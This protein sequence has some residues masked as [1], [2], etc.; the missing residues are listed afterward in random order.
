MLENRPRPFRNRAAS[1]LSLAALS[2]LLMGAKDCCCS[3]IL[4]DLTEKYDYIKGWEC[5]STSGGSGCITLQS[6]GA[7]VEIS[8]GHKASFKE[9]CKYQG[10]V[11]TVALQ[12][13]FQ[14]P[15]GMQLFSDSLYFNFNGEAIRFAAD[16]AAELELES[17][18]GGDWVAYYQ[19]DPVTPSRVEDAMDQGDFGYRLV[20]TEPL[21]ADGKA[22]P[23]TLTYAKAIKEPDTDQWIYSET[24]NPITWPDVVVSI[25]D[26]EFTQHPYKRAAGDS[27]VL[28]EIWIKNTGAT[29]AAGSQ[30]EAVIVQDGV[31]I[32]RQLLG[33]LAK[34]APWAAVPL[35]NEPV[36]LAGRA[37]GHYAATI[38]VVRPD[39]S[40]LGAKSFAV[41]VTSGV[42]P[43]GGRGRSDH[44]RQ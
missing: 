9:A 32:D 3:D 35:R 39:G 10:T 41:E 22:L 15:Q 27:L 14:V 24:T 36:S 16:P 29:L 26:E 23:A 33:T 42:V 11:N 37:V 1:A 31:E 13:G 40:R 34:L 43:I 5:E 17:R 6:T 30:V 21:P 28:D 20:H 8:S 44:P 4:E 7:H 25:A 12:V 2:V 18:F 38:A 19:V